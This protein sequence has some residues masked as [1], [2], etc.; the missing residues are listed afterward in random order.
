MSESEPGD[1]RLA[2]VPF[3]NPLMMAWPSPPWL[4][5]R[6]CL[7]EPNDGETA[8]PGDRRRPSF[9][10]GGSTGTDEDGGWCI[11]PEAAVEDDRRGRVSP[12]ES[13][14]PVVSVELRLFC[15]RLLELELDRP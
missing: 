10:I 2:L 12:R 8:I 15:R 4:S 6:E 1:S 13:K 7:D 9:I 11:M 5:C 3:P 14:R